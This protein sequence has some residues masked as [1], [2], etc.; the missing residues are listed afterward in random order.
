MDSSF[1]VNILTVL[2]RRP[3]EFMLKAMNRRFKDFYHICKFIDW[4]YLLIEI[5]ICREVFWIAGDVK[6]KIS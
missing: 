1:H 2:W 4:D 5:E 3:A 6:S